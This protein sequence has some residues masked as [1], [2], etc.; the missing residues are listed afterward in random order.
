M[1][2]I[3]TTSG[4]TEIG[5]DWSDA[6]CH[7]V[8]LGTQ[9]GPIPGTRAGI[10]SALVVDGDIYLVDAGSGLP[11]QFFDAG[12]QFQ[13]VRGMFITHL[14]SDHVADYFNFF[15]LNCTNW[16][17][18][19]QTVEVYG[20]GRANHTGADD[21]PAAGLPTGLDA[22]LVAP[23]LP[24]PGITDMTR[25]SVAA[26]AYDLNQ[27]LRSTR[28]AGAR[29]LEF[30]G[31]S[32]RPMLRP[33][34]LPIPPDAG[35]EVPSPPMAPIDVYHDEKVTVTATLVQHPP[36]FPAYAF[37]FDT[38]YGSVVFSGDTAPNPN[39]LELARGTDVLVHEVLAVEPAIERFAGTP[40]YETM[41]RQFTTGHTP[42]RTRSRGGPDE[43]P[44]VGAVAQ[45]AGAK[46]LVL[47]HIYPGDGS[48]PDED[49][50]AGAACEFAG[51]VVVGRD[52]MCL[53]LE[54]LTSAQP[55]Q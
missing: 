31:L 6:G 12:L 1:T 47:T 41:A 32:G 48:V 14:H 50:H 24:T 26:N 45:R 8:L 49:F 33:H 44:G 53:N 20:P 18:E 16:D 13:K 28:R 17:F 35:V 22:P 51:P 7:V 36:V 21:C 43:V 2:S 52:L 38:A 15:S 37:R 39:L 54:Q 9:S 5:Q 55:S 40:I 3:Q 4:V 34:D 10:A 25:L 29:A 27:R 42:H 11:R 23:E 46:S 30:T 19:T